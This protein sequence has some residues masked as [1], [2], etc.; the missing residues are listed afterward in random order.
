MML[1]SPAISCRVGRV[2]VISIGLIVLLVFGISYHSNVV[3]R[4]VDHVIHQFDC[5]ES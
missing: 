3:D 4:Y 1:S 2:G 5:M